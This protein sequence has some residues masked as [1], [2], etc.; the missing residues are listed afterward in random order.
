MTS[1][2]PVL[3]P[4]INAYFAML[5]ALAGNAQAT[6]GAG[7]AFSIDD[8]MAWFIDAARGAPTRGNKL[9][10]IG[11]GGSAAIASHIAIDYS[12]NG[13]LPTQAFND[14]AAL[15]CLGNDF[16][17]EQVFARQ[18]AMFARSGDVLIAISSSGRSA[19]ILAGVEAA[20]TAGCT[21]IT[22]SGFDPDNPLRTMGD[23]NIYVASRAYGFVEIAHLGLCHAALDTAMGW[24]ADCSETSGTVTVP[25]S[26]SP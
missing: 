17:Y 23:M 20:K 7:H 16:G 9:M 13:G 24:Q 22:F 19:N 18:I 21:V 15:T 11:N 1:T 4:N 26:Q 8:A 25:I 3:R 2:P 6:D 12:K 14:G 5:A 10:V